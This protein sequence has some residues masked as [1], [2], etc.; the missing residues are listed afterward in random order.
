VIKAIVAD[1]SRLDPKDASYF[2]QQE[3]RFETRGLATYKQLIATIRKRYGGVPV[4]A[5]E[6]I[7]EPLA[8]ALGLRLLTPNTVL[9][10]IS[11]GTE[12]TAADLTTIDRQVAKRQIEI[13]VYTFQ[14]S[15]PDV[16]R[17]TDAARRRGIPIATITET[18][19][20]ASAT[21]QQWQS[22]QL[23]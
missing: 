18:L 15:T 23:R 13:W 6:S 17:I 5:S 12:P 8:Q 16:A 21:F 19:S 9:K 3:S 4:G 10:A 20:P 2:K 11:E 1:Y 14:N 22:A 7:F